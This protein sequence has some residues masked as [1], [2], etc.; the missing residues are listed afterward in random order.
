MQ[1]RAR[2]IGDRVGDLGMRVAERRDRETGEE[3]EVALAL[4]VPEHG[5]LAAHERDRQPAVGLHHV[6]GVERARSSLERVAVVMGAPS[7]RR[8]RG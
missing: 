4:A 6:L 1:E 7:F 8:L 2:L 3:V 5:A